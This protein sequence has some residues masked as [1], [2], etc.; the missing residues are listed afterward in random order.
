MKS[1]V[2]Y[3]M[4]T[5]RESLLDEPRGSG[6]RRLFVAINCR[7]TDQIPVNENIQM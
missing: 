3:M 1:K 6:S 2:S 4:S 5:V 7:R